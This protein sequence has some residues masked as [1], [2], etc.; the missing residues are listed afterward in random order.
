MARQPA[1]TWDF[2]AQ[3]PKTPV[4]T[5]LPMLVAERWSHMLGVDKLILKAAIAV[6]GADD[7]KKLMQ[8][9]YYPKMTG[10]ANTGLTI[11]VMADGKFPQL[12]NH[13]GKARSPEGQLALPETNMFTTTPAAIPDPAI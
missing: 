13:Q 3:A 8:P 12:I 9:G 7:Q 5:D 11:A 6:L 4:S 10:A 1:I 2:P